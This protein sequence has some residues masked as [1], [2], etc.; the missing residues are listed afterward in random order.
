MSSKNSK[1]KRKKVITTAIICV[2]LAVL[3]VCV[4]IAV[5]PDKKASAPVNKC[6]Q[7][8]AEFEGIGTLCKNCLEDSEKSSVAVEPETKEDPEKE[9]QIPVNKDVCNVCKKEIHSENL[10]CDECLLQIDESFYQG[11]YSC[12]YCYKLVEKTDIAW[13]E[14]YGYIYCKNCDTGNYCSM[15]KRMLEKDYANALCENCK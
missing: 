14:S 11:E 7:C 2:V 4:Y 10:V 15:C 13:I 1:K 9:K 3:A 8:G 5:K 12:N 6:E